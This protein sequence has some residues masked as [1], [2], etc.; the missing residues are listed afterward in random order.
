MPDEG[1]TSSTQSAVVCAGKETRGAWG[2]LRAVV[3]P[4]PHIWGSKLILCPGYPKYLSTLG[5]E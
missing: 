2:G 1:V 5:F 4:Q 3:P